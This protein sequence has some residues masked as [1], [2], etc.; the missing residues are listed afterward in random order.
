MIDNLPSREIWEICQEKYGPG[1]LVDDPDYP[2]DQKA[3]IRIEVEGEPEQF[4]T[5]LFLAQSVANTIF[6]KLTERYATLSV[7]IAIWREVNGEKE[8]IRSFGR[9]V[10]QK[11]LPGIAAETRWDLENPKNLPEP[12]EERDD[13]P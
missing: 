13:T 2:E 6:R 3:Y 11:R 8:P 9:V 12:S 1:W 4:A 7:I 10:N 5:P